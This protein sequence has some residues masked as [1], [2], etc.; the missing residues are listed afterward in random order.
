[1][2]TKPLAADGM[3]M[4]PP[5]SVPVDAKQSPAAVATP[6]PL[7]EIPDQRSRAQGFRGGQGTG[8]DEPLSA[9]TN[10]LF[11]GPDSL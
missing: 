3:R 10:L 6:D 7:E 2:P 9:N 8:T 4:E 5:V 11:V 1:M